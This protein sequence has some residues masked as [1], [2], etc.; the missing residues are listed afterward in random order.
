[1]Q[2][3]AAKTGQSEKDVALAL[4]AAKDDAAEAERLLEPSIFI[5]K[6]RYAA[7]TN[8]LNGGIIIIADSAQR[9]IQK[10]KTIATYD[11]EFAELSMD[12]SWEDIEKKVVDAEI[13]QNFVPAISHDL[14]AEMEFSLNDTIDEVLPLLSAGSVDELA[15]RIRRIVCTCLGDS[16][17]DVNCLVEKITPLAMKI[18]DKEIQP[19]AAAEAGAPGEPSADAGTGAGAPPI[20]GDERHL[21]LKTDVILSPVSGT[22]VTTLNVGDYILVKITDTRQQAK[23]IADLLH[24][25]DGDK[26]LPVRVR[27]E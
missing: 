13:K 9:R 2:K 19:D 20:L 18:H 1:M 22:P 16:D 25:K 5:V 3:L 23:Y 7:K 8:R 12:P 6:G 14:A 10:V 17:V 24:A 27:S 4:K 21:V 11:A 15:T 26:M